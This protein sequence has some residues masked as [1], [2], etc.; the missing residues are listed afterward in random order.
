[1]DEIIHARNTLKKE[2][3]GYVSAIKRSNFINLV[4]KNKI[5]NLH[6]LLGSKIPRSFSTDF[7]E[8][9]QVIAAHRIH[10]CHDQKCE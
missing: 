9:R 6:R 10:K 4:N 7:R 2:C 5:G 8:F 1:M 3:S